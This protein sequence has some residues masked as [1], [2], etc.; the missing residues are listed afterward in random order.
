MASIGADMMF[1][2][3][4]ILFLALLAP[5]ASAAQNDVA[6]E[7]AWQ[8]FI[9]AF[10]VA[11]KKRDR[12]A[13]KKIMAED[14]FTSGGIGDDNQ[15]GDSRDETFAFWDKPHTRGWGAFDMVLAQ[16]YSPDGCVV[17]RW[18]ETRIRE[19]RRPARRKRPKKYQAG[20]D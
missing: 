9:V 16:G 4:A 12:A 20:A 5:P 3:S 10:R 14:F 19:P 18:G 13:L 6:A 2:L 11:V 8:P 1:S 15:D 17:G 7:R